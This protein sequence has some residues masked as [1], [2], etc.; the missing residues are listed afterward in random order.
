MKKLILL[1]SISFIGFQAFSQHTWFDAEFST[2]IVNNLELSVA[3]ELRFKEEFELNEYF[4]QTALEYQ[5]NKYFSL[6]AGYRYGYNING[7]DEHQSFGRFHL[8]AKTN[9]KWN[10]LQPKFRLRFTNADDFSDENENVNYLRYKFELEYKIKKLDLEPYVLA[11]W[12]H[13]LDAKEI[14]KSRY[15]S[16]VMYKLNKHHKIGAYYRL[17]HYLNSDKNNRNIIGISYKFKL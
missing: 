17:N 10:N 7:D 5:F 11:E 12:Y 6:A 14:S 9:V 2:E 16:G 8:D 3:P 15:E 1:L 13:D 4:L